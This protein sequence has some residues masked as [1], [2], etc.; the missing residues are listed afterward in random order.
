[1]GPSRADVLR[2]CVER[3]R[4]QGE[5]AAAGLRRRGL[6][7]GESIVGKGSG[8]GIHHAEVR[9]CD[10][11]AREQDDIEEGLHDDDCLR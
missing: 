7:F 3:R 8:Q 10:G 5:G 9:E 4:H 6:P 1:M 2:C 11:A